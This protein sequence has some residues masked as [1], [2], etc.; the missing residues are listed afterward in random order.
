VSNVAGQAYAFMAITPIVPGRE[1]ELR[2][3]LEGLSAGD[4]PLGRVRGT[5]FARW[6]ILPD[7]VNDPSQPHEDHLSVQYLIFSSNLDGPLD[8]YLDELATHLQPEAA[9][10]WGC[11]VGCPDP[12]TGDALKAYLLHNQIDTGF[13]AAAYP[14][15]TLEHVR[16]CLDERER[17]IALAVA[18]QEM[19]AAELRAAFD[20]ELGA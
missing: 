10:I 3:Y 13:F 18:S 17:A 12:P 9:T 16:S 15:A 5:H 1:A 14:N 19:S 11:C 2:A 8:A 20:R 6:V 7:W 4:S